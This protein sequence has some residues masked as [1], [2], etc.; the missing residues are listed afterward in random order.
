MENLRCLNS[1]VN[2]VVLENSVEQQERFFDK[3][4]P[5]IRIWNFFTVFTLEV[6]Y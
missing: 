3:Y 2:E 6:Q 4:K 5:V 1:P